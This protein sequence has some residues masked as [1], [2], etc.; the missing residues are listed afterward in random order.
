MR[1]TLT[2]LESDLLMLVA[3]IVRKLAEAD[4]RDR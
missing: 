3:P 4:A 2:D 1:D